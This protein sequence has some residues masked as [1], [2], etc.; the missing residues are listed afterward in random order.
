M[1]A[2]RASWGDQSA[3]NLVAVECRGHVKTLEKTLISMTIG[4][5][6]KLAKALAELKETNEE[7]ALCKKAVAQRA[8]N[9]VSH[10]TP[11]V[12]A[13]KPRSYGGS[14]NAKELDNFI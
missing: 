11:R 9:V 8:S 10:T 3:L 6:D 12:D 14:R 13:P 4:L 7:L 5:D 2:I 1:W